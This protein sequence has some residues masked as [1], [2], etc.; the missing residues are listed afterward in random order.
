MVGPGPAQRFPANI[1]RISFPTIGG[2]IYFR[3]AERWEG[4][5][6][7][8]TPKALVKG[9]PWGD[10]DLFAVV[11]GETDPQAS[12]DLKSENVPIADP[13]TDK[14]IQK[15]LYW[16]H[17]SEVKARVTTVV[18]GIDVIVVDTAQ[19]TEIYNHVVTNRLTPVQTRQEAL[20]YFMGPGLLPGQD[21]NLVGVA[22][23][24][25]FGNLLTIPSPLFYA[26]AAE[27][28]WTYHT[29]TGAAT[30]V[31]KEDNVASVVFNLAKL[32]R[33]TPNGPDGKKPAFIDFTIDLPT[34]TGLEPGTGAS[35]DW[36]AGASAWIPKD[37]PD[38]PAGTQIEAYFRKS[39]PVHDVQV[40]IS[41]I[42][43]AF[44]T[45]YNVPTFDHPDFDALVEQT[46]LGSTQLS[47]EGRITFGAGNVP[48][49]VTLFLLGG[50]GEEG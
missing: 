16:A 31:Y 4:D 43:G 47:V 37:L 39:F 49:A 14:M 8:Q 1:I 42:P 40:P 20:D 10:F 7:P 3:V 15:Y 29:E 2:L 46:F 6:T 44:N 45:D 35:I 26:M 22:I 41:G 18:P 36:N 23:T 38:P 12:N 24:D 27:A 9:L 33:D 19:W 25:V 21:P 30:N 5:A 34:R 48:P 50:G 13:I 32:F 17:W 11:G 28:G